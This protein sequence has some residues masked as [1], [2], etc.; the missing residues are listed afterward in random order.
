MLR[1]FRGTGRGAALG[2]AGFTRYEAILPHNART[3]PH[4]PTGA[5]AVKLTKSDRKQYFVTSFPKVC[6]GV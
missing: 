6:Q 4:R 3:G 5:G 1:V 2:L